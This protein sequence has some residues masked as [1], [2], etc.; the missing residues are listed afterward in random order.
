[1]DMDGQIWL[2]TDGGAIQFTSSSKVPPSVRITQILADE[3]IHPASTDGLHLLAGVR[4]VA[5]SFHAISFKTRPGGM[6]YY[7]KLVGQEDA[8]Q[9]PRRDELVEYFNLKQGEY[10]FKVQAVDH[11]LNYSAPPASVSIV[12]PAPPFYQTGIFLIAVSIIGGASLFVDIF[13]SV[14]RW[15][16]SR[17]EKLRLQ[18]EL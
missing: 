10:T 14:N 2:G 7:H 18:R 4:R 11:N 15:R 12:I 5:F 1:M 17:A 8:W 6:L 3:K 13:L 9:G 16:A